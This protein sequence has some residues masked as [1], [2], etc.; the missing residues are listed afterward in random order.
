MLLLRCH[1]IA[2]PLVRVHVVAAFG[3]RAKH[4]AGAEV[5]RQRVIAPFSRPA[6]ILYRQSVAAGNS[7]VVRLEHRLPLL[8]GSY[9]LRCGESCHSQVRL[10]FITNES[11]TVHVP[12]ERACKSL[13]CLL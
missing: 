10:A 3:V 1:A 5:A 12:S 4:V 13:L 7:T 8:V 9:H 6:S 11:V 2:R